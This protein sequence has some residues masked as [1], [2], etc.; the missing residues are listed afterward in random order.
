MESS[1]VLGCTKTDAEGRLIVYVN[2]L[3]MEVDYAGRTFEVLP[4]CPPQMLEQAKE[5]VQEKFEEK[6]RGRFGSEA[7]WK[8]FCGIFGS[9][10]RGVIFRGGER[11]LYDIAERDILRLVG[12]ASK[13]WGMEFQKGNFYT[14]Y[15]ISSGGK[16]YGRIG[17]GEGYLEKD[18]LTDKYGKGRLLIYR[19]Q[20]PFDDQMRFGGT[21][22]AEC[23]VDDWIRT[24][25]PEDEFKA[26][27]RA[28]ILAVCMF[29]GKYLGSGFG[30]CVTP[31]RLIITL[32]DPT[33]VALGT[34]PLQELKMIGIK[35]RILKDEFGFPLSGYLLPRSVDSRNS[36]ESV[37]AVYALEQADA[38]HVVA[39]MFKDTRYHYA[40]GHYD[41]NQ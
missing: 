13:T 30:G 35:R 6:Y 18:N 3:V 23:L 11:S 34:L 32:V 36:D 22:S 25:I 12:G 31:R 27:Y 4:Y 17:L 16:V 33:Q 21:C 19:A 37:R 8:E 39:K 29:A 5:G 2:A 1:G 10:E 40:Y 20:R 24:D 14:G 9:A 15:M 7:L 26:A 28:T 41:V 38:W